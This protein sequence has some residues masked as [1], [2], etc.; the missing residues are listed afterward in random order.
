MDRKGSWWMVSL[1]QNKGETDNRKAVIIV[2]FDDFS[3]TSGN[4]MFFFLVFSSIYYTNSTLTLL[5]ID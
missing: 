5:T 2:S 1:M 4:R 3:A